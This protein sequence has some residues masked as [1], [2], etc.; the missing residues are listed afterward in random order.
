MSD[1]TRRFVLPA[2]TFTIS[3]TVAYT[4]EG[5][6]TTTPSNY[7][8]LVMMVVNDGT[9]ISGSE[10]GAVVKMVNPYKW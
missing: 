3:L 10:V 8:D 6:V 4:L 1:S 9:T 5:G 2:T 7:Q